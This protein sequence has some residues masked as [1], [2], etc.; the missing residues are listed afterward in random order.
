LRTH[1]SFFATPGEAVRAGYRPCRRCRPE[2]PS[3]AERRQ[4]A[5]A[6]ACRAIAAAAT[7][8]DLAGLAAAAGLSPFHFHRVFK[9]ITGLTPHAYAA[10]HRADRVRAQLE[11]GDRTVTDAIYEAG[12]G[13]SSRFYAESAGAL[14][15]TARQF[16]SRARGLGIRV[17]VRPCALGHL[18]VAAT[19]KGVCAVMLGD[20][21]EALMRT[22]EKRFARAHIAAGDADFEGWVAAVVRYVDEPR[23]EP[24]LP[25]DLRGTAFQHR[26]WRALR[27]IPAGTTTTYAKLARQLGMPR[28]ARA[29]GSACAANPLAVIV[30]CHRV[31]RGDGDLAGYRWGVE[32]KR[33][34]LARESEAL[35]VHGRRQR[36]QK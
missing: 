23:H 1:V 7:P 33:Q 26:V 36:G 17:A 21:R 6:A 10:A 27:R 12:F 15:M 3:I 16:R 19:D 35:A 18:L 8:P 30:P 22:L 4:R 29:I 25:L 32:R 13:S 34:L 24:A 11:G 20:D 2:G 9:Q 5:V 28:G 31:L 14:G